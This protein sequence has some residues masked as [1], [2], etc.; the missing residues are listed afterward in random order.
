MSPVTTRDVAVIGA[1]AAGPVADHHLWQEGYKD[2]G[3]EFGVCEMIRFDTEVCRVW[4]N[5]IGKW[6]VRSR[7]VKSDGEGV[8][9]VFDAVVVCNGH[10][11]EPRIAYI[12][13]ACNLQMLINDNAE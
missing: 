7:K 1:R 9:E 2:Y 13:G 6:E 12:P 10:H 11:T 4:R 3:N 8:S 5:G